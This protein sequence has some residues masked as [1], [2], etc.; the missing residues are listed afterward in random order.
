MFL[1]F[2]TLLLPKL[3]VLVK[4]Q[5]NF[6]DILEILLLDIFDKELCIPLRKGFG[7]KNTDVLCPEIF[8][9]EGFVSFLGVN[10]VF[11]AEELDFVEGINVFHSVACF[12]N[13]DVELSNWDIGLSGDVVG[14]VFGVENLVE[15]SAIFFKSFEGDFGLDFSE[16]LVDFPF[17]ESAEDSFGLNNIIF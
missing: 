1:L 6:F 7:V 14:D 8:L 13:G 11:L 12:S 17:L 10:V 3:E 2:W 9:I 4:R 16:K 15:E 5:I